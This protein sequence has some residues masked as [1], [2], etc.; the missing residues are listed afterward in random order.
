MGG[1]G[2]RACGCACRLQSIRKKRFVGRASARHLYQR[3]QLAPVRA[4]RWVA[5]H[6]PRWRLPP[7]F[8][9]PA[10]S[11]E[12]HAGGWF[13]RARHRLA[14]TG[15]GCER[16]C[17]V[18]LKR[19]LHCRLQTVCKMTCRSGF[20]PTHEPTLATHN[21]RGDPLGRPNITP[22]VWF[23][24]A[25]HRLAPTGAGCEYRHHL[26]LKR[27]LHCRLQ[28]VCKMTC[29]SGFSPTFPIANGNPFA[30]STCRGDSPGR[31]YGP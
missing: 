24:R 4:P 16:R 27:D 31:P 10:G 20:S 12:H 17:H 5:R 11:P 2:F 13:L 3:L 6:C 7:L 19:D 23:L 1:G 26:A 15:A 28:T 22:A 9:R 18:A 8:G 25:R 14:P 29:R 21:C 30:T